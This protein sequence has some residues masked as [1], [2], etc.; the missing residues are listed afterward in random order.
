MNFAL[1]LVSNR[2]RG[3]R[4]GTSLAGDALAGDVS[5]TTA[6]TIARATDARQTA[7]LTLGSPEFQR[8]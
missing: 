2:M 1:Q 3:V 5:S 4:A 7:A 8:R 6:A